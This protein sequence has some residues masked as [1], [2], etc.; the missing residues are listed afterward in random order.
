MK[1]KDKARKGRR[2]LWAGACI[3]LAAC[4]G[5]NAGRAG[6]T[7]DLYTPVGEYP[8]VNKRVEMSLFAMSAP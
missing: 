7:G 6:D 3:L 2:F 1:K 8:I 4:G 5:K